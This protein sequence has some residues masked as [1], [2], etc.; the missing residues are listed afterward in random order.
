MKNKIKTINKN[1]IKKNKIKKN[2]KNKAQASFEFM[3]IF[4]L[5]LLIAT[6]FIAIFMNYYIN[7]QNKSIQMTL[8][9]FAEQIGEKINSAYLGGD[10]FQINFYLPPKINGKD[11]HLILNSTAKYLEVR[12]NDTKFENYGSAN[13]LTSNIQLIQWNENQTIENANGKI[14]IKPINLTG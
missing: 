5:L 8:T 9:N 4:T 13:L 3:Q 11:Y 10:G 12:L 7:I 14:I 2:N 6:I 1:N